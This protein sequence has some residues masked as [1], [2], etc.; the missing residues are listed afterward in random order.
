MGEIVCKYCGKRMVAASSLKSCS[1]CGKLF[2]E[3][4]TRE[5]MIIFVPKDYN[6]I[7]KS[8]E[9]YINDRVYTLYHDEIHNIYYTH[10]DID[11]NAC[12]VIKG[13]KI[14]K[15]PYVKK[16]DSIDAEDMII[17]CHEYDCINKDHQLQKV[18]AKVRAID[19][20]GLFEVMIPVAYCPKCDR[21]Y[22][23]EK[24]YNILK[25]YGYICCRVDIY[26]S[27]IANGIVND[28]LQDKVILMQYGY[29]VSEEAGLSEIERHNVLDFIIDNGVLTKLEV[30]DRIRWLISE[31]QNR[32]YTEDEKNKLDMDINYV[33]RKNNINKNVLIDTGNEPVGRI[34]YS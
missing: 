31:G 21:Y 8:K 2:T 16:Y 34:K 4:L 3:S 23:L 7:C 19:D 17:R 29:S 9:V 10:E 1:Y 33:R 22:V 14:I 32:P 26:D 25:G 30:I 12:T 28:L 15:S 13:S 11:T 24:F 27:L 6:I 20:R 5:D 18:N